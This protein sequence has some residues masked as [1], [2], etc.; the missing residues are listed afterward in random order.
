MFPSISTA[1]LVQCAGKTGRFPRTICDICR[2]SIESIFCSRVT[3]TG[4]GRSRRPWVSYARC[5]RRPE[6]T[7]QLSVQFTQLSLVRASLAYYFPVFIQWLANEVY[8]HRGSLQRQVI[9]PLVRA[10][11][12]SPRSNPPAQDVAGSGA[13]VMFTLR[14]RGARF[15]DVI[16]ATVRRLDCSDVDPFGVRKR[17]QI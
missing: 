6:P 14:F 10:T 5:Q 13:P 16:L 9:P 11:L 8:R 17:L 3:I 15:H 1:L 7:K 2:R 4:I 12:F